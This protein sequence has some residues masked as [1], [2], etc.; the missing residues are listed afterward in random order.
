MRPSFNLRLPVLFVL[1]FVR[2]AVAYEGNAHAIMTADAFDRSILA[3]AESGPLV[4]IG[5][6]RPLTRKFLSSGIDSRYPSGTAREI[7][8]FGARFEDLPDKDLRFLRHF[9]DPQNHDRGLTVA[10]ISAHSSIDWELEKKGDIPEQTYS[11][12]DAQDFY[13]LALVSADAAMRERYLVLLLEAIGRGVHHLQDMAQPAHTRNDP[14]PLGLDLDLYERATDAIASTDSAA[15]PQGMAY[16]TAAV[17]LHT[18]N[19]FGAFWEAA[20]L[21][22]AEFTATNFLSQDTNFTSLGADLV[23]APEFPLP[24]PN[25]CEGKP[26]ISAVTTTDLD[27]RPTELSIP[28]VMLFIGTPVRDRYLSGTEQTLCNSRSSAYGLFDLDLAALG[29]PRLLSLNR[30][31]WAAAREILIPRAI[32]YSAGLINYFFRGVLA[33]ESMDE[34][35]DEI[36]VAIRND[37][38][39][40]FALADGAR[41]GS[42]AEFEIWYE[43]SNGTRKPA[44]LL[45]GRDLTGST[46]EHGGLRQLRFKRPADLSQDAAL[47]FM[48]VFRGMV[49]TEE[50]VAGLAFAPQ[51]PAFVVTPSYLTSDAIPG[52]RRLE[53]TA[54]AWAATSDAG[55]VAGN[56]DW[57]GWQQADLITWNGPQS[58]YFFA[59]GQVEH[60]SSNLYSNG[61]LLASAPGALIGAAIR[62]EGSRAELLAVVY[63]NGLLQ[64]HVRNLV[65]DDTGPPEWHEIY[66]MPESAPATPAFANASGTEFQLL[67]TGAERVKLHVDGGSVSVERIASRGSGSQSGQYSAHSAPQLCGSHLTNVES[68]TVSWDRP[69]VVCA[70]YSGDQEILCEIGAD[71]ARSLSQESNTVLSGRSYNTDSSF[72]ESISTRR[73]LKMGQIQIPLTGSV[74]STDAS[75]SDSYYPYD[76]V[77]PLIN[78]RQVSKTTGYDTRILY[79][80]ARNGIAA[81]QERNTIRNTASIRQGATLGPDGWLSNG[82][83]TDETHLEVR[84]TVQH[85]G[86]AETLDSYA[87]PASVLHNTPSV[88]VVY[89]PCGS[90]LPVDLSGALAPIAIDDSTFKFTAFLHPRAYQEIATQGFAVNGAGD[91]LASVPIIRIDARGAESVSDVWNFLEG[92]DLVGLLPAA[93]ADAHYFPLGPAR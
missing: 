5:L 30:Y 56:I 15:F 52:A 11:L 19:T 10:G 4:R 24:G 35:N 65:A 73:T 89:P 42:T 48:L 66:A 23:P 77:P 12:R 44:Q 13:Y 43:T 39:G 26:L 93:P 90:S 88:P 54:G 18:F 9:L 57:R 61:R 37:S 67:T 17:D 75:T 27:L 46:I 86:R 68:Y 76:P 51:R 60:L 92:G 22:I 7:A 31:T 59:P 58:R 63:K 3:D 85:G 74:F 79:L 91:F 36:A 16:P 38:M 47:P 87:G 29:R 6:E 80:D 20:G 64:M 55:S 82:D 83:Y 45:E 33:I 81:Y 2:Q 53:R 1:C 70:D 40:E 25:P 32:A 62:R 49:G 69:T 21:G 14:H 50:G 8:S 71:G 41:S 72:H 28:G 84:L 34:S 78:E